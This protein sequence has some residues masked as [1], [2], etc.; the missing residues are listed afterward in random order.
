MKCIYNIVQQLAQDTAWMK[1]GGFTMDPLNTVFTACKKC[2]NWDKVEGE[3][4]RCKHRPGCHEDS[5]SCRNFTS[6]SLCRSKVG[7]VFNLS[8]TNK[9]GTKSFIDVDLN[10]PTLD[11]GSKFKGFAHVYKEYLRRGKP[12]GWLKEF[13]KQTDMD[14][15]FGA[16]DQTG[17]RFRHISPDVILASQVSVTSLLY[18]VCCQQQ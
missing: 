14:Y 18:F 1:E 3:V 6:P 5:C 7:A 9:D 4:V 11:T 17:V 10:C 12:I 15:F 8:F 13:M 16:Q 2:M